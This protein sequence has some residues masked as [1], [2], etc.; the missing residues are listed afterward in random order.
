MSARPEF[1][2]RDVDVVPA[3]SLIAEPTRAAMITALLD[4]RP[5]AAGE[6]ARLAG[7]SPATASAHL[8]RLLNG[9]LVTMIKQ[10]RHRYYHLA[11]PEVAAAM[12]ALAH[13][14]SANPVQVRSLRE[15]RDAAALAEA[16]TCYDHL[17]GRAGVALLEALLAGGI[18]APAPGGGQL[19]ACGPNGGAHT[20]GNGAPSASG[21]GG[22]GSPDGASA[23]QAG[24]QVRAA[25]QAM[26][27][28]EAFEVTADGMATLTSFGLNIGALE[29]T[30]RRFAGACLDWTERK[31]H[32][33]G[34]LG[35]AMTARLLGLGWIERGTRRRAVRVT[36]AGRDGLVATFGWSLEG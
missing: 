1:I 7:V 28:P 2:A 36:P 16:R 20:D 29:K 10:G 12:E 33:N 32:L 14:S 5:L 31:P 8:A 35:A 4:D 34:A 3:A 13:L 30:R 18:L 21:P 23:G 27:R 22:N 19:A 26:V 17:A 11:G 24:R 9:G 6:L 25:P 15:S